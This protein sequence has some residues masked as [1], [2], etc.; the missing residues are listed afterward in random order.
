M[1][2]ENYQDQLEDLRAAV[3]AMA[4]TTLERYTDAVEILES[5]A[6][7]DA[8][9]IIDGDEEINRWYLDIENDCIQLLARQQPVAGD[10]RFIAS[11]FKIVTDLERIG[12][13]ATNLAAY[14]RDADGRMPRAEELTDIAGVAGEMVADAMDAY[15]TEDPAAARAVAGRDDDLDRRCRRAS[16]D[17]VREL[18]R[19]RVED[20]G[21]EPMVEDA[22]QALLT[23]RD[24]ERVGDHAVNICARTLYMIESDEELIY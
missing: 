12:D 9:R 16:E 2:R 8:A 15:T 19:A 1:T 21:L 14:G 23:I 18:V 10:L 13:L 7:D 11:T 24:T 17:V 6:D 20:I 5:G 4:E 22:S 3:D